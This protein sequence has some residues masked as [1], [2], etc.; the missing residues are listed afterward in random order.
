MPEQAFL[1]LG[2]LV[3]IRRADDQTIGGGTLYALREFVH[4]ATKQFTFLPVFERHFLTVAIPI[5]CRRVRLSSI[6]QL[7]VMRPLRILRRSVAMNE[8]GWPSPLAVS[9]APVKCPVK[10]ICTVT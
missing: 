2:R 5:C 6:C 9:K 10:L 7:S 3:V 8:T 1:F 4:F